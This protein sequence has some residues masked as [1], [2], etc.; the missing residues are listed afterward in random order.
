MNTPLA[1][2]TKPTAARPRALLPVM[3][4][5]LALTGCGSDEDDTSTAPTAL[6]QLSAAQ[7]GTLSGDCASLATK[8][9][10]LSNISVTAVTTIAAGGLKIGGQDIAEHCQVTALTESRTSP[11]DGQAYAIRFEMRLPKAWNGRFFHQGNGGLDGS[12]LAATGASGG[13]PLTHALAQGFAV[14]S[15]DAGHTAAQNP[16]FGIDPQARLNYGYQAAATLTPI[17][18][19]IIQTAY[20]RNADRAYF[21]GC[22]NGGRHAMV[23]A[24]RMPES[25]DGYL[26]GAP[27]FNLPKAATANIYKGQRYAMVASSPTTDLST[28]ITTAE[29]KVVA[30]AVLAKCD[31]LDGATDG[32]VQ[33]T[34]ACQ[35]AF[36]WDR[37]VPT[38]SGSTRDGTC[39]TAAQKTAIA[40][41]FSGAV[42]S[43]GKAFYA[44]FPFDP[45]Y[46]GSGIPSWAF[47]AP[48]Q[49]DAVA[50]A[51]TFKTPPDNPVGFDGVNFALNA[52]IDTL[53]QQ[54]E[55]TNATYTESSMAF[56]TPPSPTDLS[57]LKNRGAKMMVYHGV[58]DPIF[59]VE[60]TTTW[61]KALAAANSG[62]ASNFARFFRVPGMG[63]CS[64][65]PATDQFDAVSALVKW[66]EQ[67]QAP[68]SLIA[69]ARGTGN[70]GGVNADVPSTWAVDRSRPL[71]AWPKVA[72]YKGTGSL[73]DAGSFE[74]RS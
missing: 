61:Y 26:V 35:A 34:D 32:L 48:S 23:A 7:A 74:C 21:G 44:R 30:D 45:G 50:I 46:A 27:G 52:N 18:H 73:D 67:G 24:A 71:C 12:V 68:D 1:S 22:S 54:I 53:L 3:L 69:K 39:L 65:G 29:R 60:D 9:N 57:K 43:S 40:P 28:A 42:D 56:M 62:D 58:S 70:A 72:R 25:Y 16:A 6:P 8:L 38:C 49:R 13:G 63:H 33:D 36:Q 41:I 10:S 31:A 17:A 37:D 20:G 66:V 59:S 11:V 15:S 19:A 4:A 14:L 47:T 51:F 2:R 55:A 64:G 5:I